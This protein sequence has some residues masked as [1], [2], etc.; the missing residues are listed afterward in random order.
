VSRIEK[1]MSSVAILT[2]GPR[3]FRSLTGRCASQQR[4][5]ASII[6]ADASVISDLRCQRFLCASKRYRSRGFVRDSWYV[7]C[8]SRF[9]KGDSNMSIDHQRRDSASNPAPCTPSDEDIE[10]AQAIREALRRL[11]LNR[12]EEDVGLYGATSA[13]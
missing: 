11:L 10:K 9:V 12:P 2:L 1:Q 3:G 6:A 13:D 4:S 8:C 7:V 5:V